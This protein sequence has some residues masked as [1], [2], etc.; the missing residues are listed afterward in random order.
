MRPPIMP[1]NVRFRCAREFGESA[2]AAAVYTHADSEHF[3]FSGLSNHC[4]R[5]L[6]APPAINGL[7]SVSFHL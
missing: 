6:H 1:P 5:Y 2:A 4:D 7:I 3:I